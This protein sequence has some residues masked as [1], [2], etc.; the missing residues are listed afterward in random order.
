MTHQIYYRKKT[1]Q[2]LRKEPLGTFIDELETALLEKGYPKRYLR[3]RFTVIGE[4]NHWLIQKKIKLCNL[5][6]PQIERFTQHRSKQ[7]SMIKLGE[8]VTL[9][10]LFEVLRSHGC[11]PPP[12]PE[13]IYENEIETLLSSYNQ[14]LI[15]DQGLSSSTISNYIAHVSCFLL[16]LF[17]SKPIKLKTIFAQNIME[18]VRKYANEHSSVENSLMVSSLRSFFRFLLLRGSIAVDLASCVPAV[19]NRKHNRIPQSLSSQEL[20]HLLEHSKGKTALELRN[21]ALLLLLA[22]L[23]LRA[24]EI[25]SLTLDDIDWEHGEIVVRGKGASQTRFPLPVDVGEALVAYLK[26]GRP[27]YSTRRIF[28]CSKPPLKPI[29]HPSTVSTIVRSSLKHAGLNPPNKG[30]HLFRHTLATECLRKG[31]TLLEIGEIL[32][33]RQID[34]TAIYAKVDFAKL[35]TIAQPW[36]DSSFVGGAL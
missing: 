7:T 36:P 2:D 15:E 33:H 34:T 19:A 11:I 25:V 31:A 12:E 1:E 35:K 22:R 4:L 28:I 30:A 17:T 21:Y 26:K 6:Q 20:E 27:S 9:K 18:F 3:S 8:R 23:G 16:D 5:N 24:S 32:R 29:S 10:F 13:K 14:Y